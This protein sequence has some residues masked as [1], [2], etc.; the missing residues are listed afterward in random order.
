MTSEVIFTKH[1]DYKRGIRNIKVKGVLL[2]LEHGVRTSGNQPG[3][4]RHKLNING[5]SD[6]YVVSK[7]LPGG[8][9]LILTTYIRGDLDNGK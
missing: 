4:F 7:P 2:T 5:H 1:A 8:K 9:T 6:C 3:T